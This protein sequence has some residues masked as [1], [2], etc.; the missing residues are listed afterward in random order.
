MEYFRNLVLEY[1][2]KSC[3]N[4]RNHL[5]VVD[6]SAFLTKRSPSGRLAVL[7]PLRHISE[8]YRLTSSFCDRS[9]QSIERDKRHPNGE[10]ISLKSHPT[11]TDFHTGCSNS[12]ADRPHRRFPSIRYR[13]R[14]PLQRIREYPTMTMEDQSPS[15]PTEGLAL[16]KELPTQPP[17]RN[18]TPISVPNAASVA[19]SGSTL[20]TSKLGSTSRPDSTGPAKVAIP[21]SR[22]G[23]APRYGR[24]VPRACESCRS[25]KTKCSGDTPVC[26][27]CRELRISCQYPVGWKEKTKK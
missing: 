17:D 22:S 8:Y 2:H 5:L 19:D 1:C 4:Y 14:I 20:K 9:L 13:F 6:I 23:I 11:A 26:R 24:R 27:Q 16:Q 15:H 7:P 18:D 12:I 21:R 10:H 25:R 3:L